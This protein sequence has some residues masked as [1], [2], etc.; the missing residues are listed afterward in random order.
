[1][2]LISLI[3]NLFVLNLIEEAILEGGSYK[4]TMK[5]TNENAK[6]RKVVISGLPANSIA[7]KLDKIDSEALKCFLLGEKGEVTRCDYVLFIEENNSIYFIELKSYRPKGPK[8]ENQFKSSYCLLKYFCALAE[9][10]HNSNMLNQFTCRYLVFK[11]RNINK[12][13]TEAERINWS[14]N[15]YLKPLTMNISENN[16]TI[17][18]QKIK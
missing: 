9:K 5:E 6:L 12:T 7:L 14:G 13:K 15:S 1:M 17:K 16:T 10:F 8:I 2:D 11:I 4:I 18:Y 3:K